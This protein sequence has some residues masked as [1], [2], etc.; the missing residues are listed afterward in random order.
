MKTDLLFLFAVLISFTSLAQ[1]KTGVISSTVKDSKNEAIIGATVRLLKTTDTAVVTT[2]MTDGDGKFQFINVD[3]GVYIL[4]ITAVGKKEFSS[5]PL[6]VMDSK[7]INLPMIIL[8]PAKSTELNEVVIKAKRPLIQMEIDKT[9]VNV[10]A[11]ISSASSNT[12]EV[13]EKTP[14]IVINS[15]GDITLNGRSGVMVLIDGRPTYMSGQDLSLYL[16]SLP[17]SLLDKIELMDNPPAR[18]DASGNAIINIKLK[19]NRIG[20]FV[21]SIATGYSQGKYGKSNNSLNL[22][23]NYKKINLFGSMGYSYEKSYSNDNFTRNFFDVNNVPTSTVF[24]MNRQKSKSEG[25]NTNLGLDYASTPNTTYGIQLNLNDNKNN[26]V[27]NYYSDN[28]SA[29]QLDNIG[30]GHTYGDNNRTNL[31]TNINFL[32]KFG[33]TGKE[34]S[35]DINYLNYRSTGNQ[36]LINNQDQFFYNLPSKINIYTAKADYVQTIKNNARFEA[37]FKSSFVIND[38]KSDYY[39][40]TDQGQVIDNGKS[41]HFK[42][43]ENINSAYI[44]A[45]K[46]WKYLS[47]QLGLRLENTQSKG[48]QLGNEIVQQS[49]FSKNYTQVFPTLFLNYKFDTVGRNTL[50]FSISK[51]INRPNYQYLNP[52]LFFRDRYSY[53]VGNPELT[54]QY[55]FRYEL[56]Y[57]Y[58]QLLRMGLSYNRFTDVIFQTTKVVD[59]VFIKKPENVAFGYMLLLNNSISLTPKEWWSLNLELQFSKMG[60]NGMA[61]GEKL[62]PSTYVARIGAYNQFQFKKGWS[63]ELNSYYASRDLNGQSF[64]SGMY[65]VNAGIQ[66]KIWK[67][68][69]SIRINMDDI[70]HSWVYENRSVGLARAYSFQISASDTQR[71]GIA[72]TYRFGKEVFKRKSKYTNHTL[73]E[74]KSRM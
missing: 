6:H 52:F 68:K 58:K 22:N 57:Q 47:V 36:S 45:Q 67:D 28:Y 25:L 17:G 60:L 53:T 19:K 10:D 39:N 32:H 64:T 30:K 13:L 12:L 62:N 72:L 56:K 74:E 69:G 35:A 46:G 48:Q 50:N 8:F 59:D 34:L 55:Q 26:E 3:I 4:K 61:Y 63:A 7:G 18:Y 38:N 11:M 43:R 73:D 65:R 16:K 20:G 27:L 29:G 42:F 66:K 31:G 37:G 14:G 5:V 23:Y 41:N 1:V 2:K 44:N 70:F 9:V 15:G 49:E 24:L 40:I 71:L 54:P 33:K 51:R 21:G